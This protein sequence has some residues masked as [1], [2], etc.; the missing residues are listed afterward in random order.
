MYTYKVTIDRVV[1]GDTVDVHIDL[2]FNVTAFK[3]IRLFGINA[4]ETR[5]KDLEEKRKGIESK[6]WLEK[7]LTSPKIILMTEKDDTGKYGRVLGTFFVAGININ[8]LMLTSKLALPYMI[9]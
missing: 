8:E 3:R 6:E 2:G 7:L 5:T 4:P 1:D 9:D